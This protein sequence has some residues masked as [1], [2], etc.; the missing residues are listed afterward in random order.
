MLK[1]IS[2]YNNDDEPE[3]PDNNPTLSFASTP[4]PSFMYCDSSLSIVVYPLF[5]CCKEMQFHL[6]E[7][8]ST[9][10]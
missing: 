1:V 7:F 3:I 10:E 4:P 8:V 9:Q 5:L 2:V 6:L